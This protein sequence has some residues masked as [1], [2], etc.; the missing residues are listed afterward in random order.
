MVRATATVV[1]Y[2]FGGDGTTFPAGWT[3]TTVGKICDQVDDELDEYGLS[4]SDA[5]AVELANMLVYRRVIHS[6][7]GS[8]QPTTMMEPKV[9]TSDMIDLL[10]RLSE[11]GTYEFVAVVDTVNDGDR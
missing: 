8:S 10:N 2:K 4:A 1:S 7:W 9:W 5:G 3:A 11:R 6:N